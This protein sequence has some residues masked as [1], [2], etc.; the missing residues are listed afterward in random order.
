MGSM[1]VLVVDD[2]ELTVA[3]VTFVLEADG[4]E[5][6]SAEDAADAWPRIRA[7]RPDVI[8]LDIQLPRVSGLALTRRIKANPEIRAI[9]VVALTAYAM[10]GD[11]FRMRAAGCDGYISKPIE[12][13]T[14][15]ARVRSYRDAAPLAEA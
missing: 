13:N 7:F 6:E 14:L 12:V 8:L 9:P 4:I 2:N 11:E 5:V 10:K 3:L 15:A 1:R